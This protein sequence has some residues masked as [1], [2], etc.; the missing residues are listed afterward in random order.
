MI[1][2][3]KK[4]L[5]AAPVHHV[6]TDWMDVNGFECI[7]REKITQSEA[8][9]LVRD[10]VGIVTSTRLQIDKK[11]MDAAPSLR[12]VGRMGSGMEVIDVQYAGAKGIQCYSSPE[13]NSNAVA[14]HAL[15][16]LLALTKKIVVSNN[17][18]KQG[19]WIRDANRG[20]EL[21]GKTIAIIGFGNTGRA[22]AKKLS[23][24]GMKILIYDKYNC[25]KIPLYVESCNELE[26]IYKEADILSF[27]VPLQ[28]D[29]IHYFNNVF[30]GKISKPYILINTSRGAIIETSVL[31]N[32]LKTGRMSG[33]CLDVWE[34]EPI[35]KMDDVL[36]KNLLEIAQLPQV[37]ITPHIAGYSHEAVYKMS[38]VLL[39][40]IV[41]NG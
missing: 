13:G 26:R 11:L 9:V 15:G 1:A 7:V 4:V 20:I 2:A 16:M 3:K 14:E 5:I 17:E 10:C 22:F 8:L 40:K 27:H 34:Q 37:I 39:D 38:K 6:L 31:L 28:D 12:W 24:F 41:I 23:V 36:R 33:A 19:L 32:E 35:E 25:E 30:A 21:E 29:T 18:V